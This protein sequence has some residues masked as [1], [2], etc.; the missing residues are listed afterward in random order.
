MQQ[1]NTLLKDTLD[2]IQTT[3]MENEDEDE[4]DEDETIKARDKA[5]RLYKG[6]N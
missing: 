1:V 6:Q 2:K 5:E 4:A 3:Q